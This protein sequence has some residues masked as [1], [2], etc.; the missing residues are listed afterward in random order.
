VDRDALLR[1]AKWLLEERP[2]T[3]TERSMLLAE[4]W[5]DA[6]PSALAYAAT[7]HIALCQVPPRGIW[8]KNGPAAWAPVDSQMGAH[9]VQCRFMAVTQVTKCYRLADNPGAPWLTLIE[10]AG[11][12]VVTVA[13]ASA[14]FKRAVRR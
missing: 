14:L 6:D 5:P 11:V 10:F 8:G 7:H 13:L 2:L 1:Q 12:I 4:H 3:R 9:C